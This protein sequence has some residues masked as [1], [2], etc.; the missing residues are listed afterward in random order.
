MPCVLVVAGPAA[1]ADPV[2]AAD[3]ATAVS[4]TAVSANAVS[5]EAVTP[6]SESHHVVFLEVLGKGGLWGAGYEWRGRRF[7]V[8]GV[9]SYYQLGGDRFTTVSPYIGASLLGGPHAS[10]FVHVGPQLVR[11]TT[12]SPGPEWM[13]LTTTGLDAELST[14]IESTIGKLH[15]RAYA[16]AEVG[17]HVA[18]GV[19]AGIGWSL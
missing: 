18:G 1:A 5:A 4:A 19:G 7:V 14:G 3:P 11:R 10:W 6:P 8:G 12:P 15:L 16:M 17:A 9:G 13:G 2:A